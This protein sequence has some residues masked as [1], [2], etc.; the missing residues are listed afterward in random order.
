MTVIDARN[1]YTLY[2][3]GHIP[4]AVYLNVAELR[5]A[6]RGVP[7]EILGLGS[8]SPPSPP[9]GIPA[10]RQVGIYTPGEPPNNNATYPP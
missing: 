7:N 4:R 8:H 1:D 6:D 9:L 5:A 2:L 3:E 10:D